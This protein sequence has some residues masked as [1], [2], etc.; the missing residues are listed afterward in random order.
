MAISG[1]DTATI[2]VDA[3]CVLGEGP[4]W[5]A[6]RASLLWT[7]IEDARLWMH[8]SGTGRT[9][10]WALPVRVGAFVLCES[11]RVLLGL[12]KGLAFADIDRHDGDGVVP[13]LSVA[14]V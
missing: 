6:R 8:T 7:D 2:C 4:V 1:N 14:A 5:C 9:R 13:L 3:M 10:S 11:G 12:A